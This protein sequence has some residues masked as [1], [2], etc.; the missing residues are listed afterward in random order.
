MCTWKLYIIF[1]IFF[2]AWSHRTDWLLKIYCGYIITASQCMY[3]KCLFYRSCF[4]SSE[5]DN[6]LERNI[7]FIA[8]VLARHIFNLT[9]KVSPYH[10]L[11]EWILIT[12]L[13]L[14]TFAVTYTCKFQCSFLHE[15]LSVWKHG[16]SSEPRGERRSTA[17]SKAILVQI[18]SLEWKRTLQQFNACDTSLKGWFSILQAVVRF[19]A[20]G[21]ARY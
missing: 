2:K 12:V 21:V 4:R 20:H 16:T 18:C 11:R 8:E 9:T 15:S 17:L 1:F 14:L 5:N 19:P 6:K 10:A 7:E 3:I 13:F